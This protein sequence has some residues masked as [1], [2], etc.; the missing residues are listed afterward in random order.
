MFY[1]TNKHTTNKIFYLFSGHES[2]TH[3]LYYKQVIDQQPMK[4]ALPVQLGTKTSKQGCVFVKDH[5]S[6]V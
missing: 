4:A 3:P 5:L 6:L 2:A 1:W